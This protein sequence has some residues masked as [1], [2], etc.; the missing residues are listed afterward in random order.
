MRTDKAS[1]QLDEVLVAL[2]EQALGHMGHQHKIE[3]IGFADFTKLL[4]SGEIAGVVVEIF[5]KL[6]PHK[7][8]RLQTVCPD[9]LTN[10]VAQIGH[11]QRQSF[12]LTLIGYLE[13]IVH[14]PCQRL[15]GEGAQLLNHRIGVISAKEVRVSASDQSVEVVFV[16]LVREPC[17][18]SILQRIPALVFNSGIN[19]RLFNAFLDGKDKIM[20]AADR[21][22]TIAVNGQDT[23]AGLHGL[24]AV[25]QVVVHFMSLEVFTGFFFAGIQ[26][27]FER[28]NGM[29]FTGSV[30]TFHP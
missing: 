5:G 28:V 22:G 13:D 9:D 6:V 7:D 19:K 26:Q 11:A 21:S 30:G 8:N 27:L 12:Y 4:K 17:N 10:P 25:V 1:V 15:A 20:V 18:G 2:M 23:T 16:I 29:G 24:E 3:G 14:N